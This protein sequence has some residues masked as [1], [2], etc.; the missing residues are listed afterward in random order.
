MGC[1]ETIAREYH[2]MNE[3]AVAARNAQELIRTLLID[4]APRAYRVVSA[5]F[6]ALTAGSRAIPL[7]DNGE[8]LRNLA[9]RSGEAARSADGAAG[10][11][12]AC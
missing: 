12:R 10:I 9:V 7:G 2:I 4:G 6:A 1:R 11:H 3:F 8:L 5:A